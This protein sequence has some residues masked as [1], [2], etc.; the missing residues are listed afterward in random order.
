VLLEAVRWDDPRAAAL[1][2]EMFDDVA[3][4]YP[5]SRDRV[6]AIGGYAAYDARGAAGLVA[7]LLATA[8]GEPVG[9]VAVRRL[10]PDARPAGED[11]VG[12]IADVGEL[13]RMYV[14]P[15]ARGRGVARALLAA[16]EE[17]ATRAGLTR[18]V[19]ETGTAQVAAQRLY[20]AAG[21]ADVPAY[22]PHVGDPTAVCLGKD[23][24]GA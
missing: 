14:R 20:R 4:L 22:P 9:F 2:R 10:P 6:A 19:L 5:E 16:A 21:Y 3:L 1:R 24:P 8:D 18:M 11:D 15:A 13:R 12:G 7:A 17:A 23:L